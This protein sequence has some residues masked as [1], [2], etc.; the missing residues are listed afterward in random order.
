MPSPGSHMS[1][2]RHAHADAPHEPL[3]PEQ[4]TR[5]VAS[6]W[7]TSGADDLRATL[8]RASWNDTYLVEHG[9][10][11]TILRIGG[12]APAADAYLPYPFHG[13]GQSAVA[14]AEEAR[15]LE[16]LHAGG[17]G[18]ARA[19]PTR[20]GDW[21]TA[22]ST[23][24][25]ERHLMRF[26]FAPGE[27]LAP[28]P[29]VRDDWSGSVGHALG[30]LHAVAADAPPFV[31]RPPRDHHFLLDHPLHRIR[32]HLSATTDAAVQAQAADWLRLLETTATQTAADLDALVAAGLPTGV[33]HGDAFN[34]NASIVADGTA[35]GTADGRVTWYDFDLAGP[36]WPARDLAGAWSCL[37]LH[38]PNV[39]T[40][41]R[42]RRWQRFLAAYLAANPLSPDALN[43]T[44]QAVPTLRAA[45]QINSIGLHLAHPATRR[46]PA[47]RDVAWWTR[48][49]AALA[50]A[51]DAAPPPPST[52]T[53]R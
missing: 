37:Q 45:G 30:R 31:A 32:Q 23:P 12:L 21:T 43:V 53:E 29:F 27:T 8:L 15:L 50:A 26:T 41:D 47:A 19:L 5:L 6:A 34:S 24:E 3:P 10:E 2:P 4:V 20:A 1:P 40:A 33:A 18:V 36:G 16:H 39:A 17:V 11:R 49:L 22:V 42:D 46:Q 35:D 44:L 51:Q 28:H 38:L 48:A 13:G 25:G 52:L 9:S 14:L 7:G